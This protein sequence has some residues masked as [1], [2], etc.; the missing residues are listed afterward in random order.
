MDDEELEALQEELA[1]VRAE[2][3]RLQVEAADAQARI[4]GLA[5]SLTTT[6]QEIEQTRQARGSLESDYRLAVDEYR[7]VALAAEPDLPPDLVSGETLEAVQVSLAS[8]RSTVDQVRERLAATPT[9]ASGGPARVSPG[10]PVRR[11]PDTSALSPE[12]KIAE[13]LRRGE[14]GR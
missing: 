10:A 6:R 5:D 12:Q 4:R 3:E 13:G 14:V 1:E 2:N 9:P 11:E 7:R 8:A